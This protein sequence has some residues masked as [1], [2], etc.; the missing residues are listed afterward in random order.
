MMKLRPSSANPTRTSRYASRVN[1]SSSIKRDLKL[2][3]SSQET[4]KFLDSQIFKLTEASFLDY[5]SLASTQITQELKILKTHTNKTQLSKTT[6]NWRIEK[7]NLELEQTKSAENYSKKIPLLK[8]KIEKLKQEIIDAKIQQ[9]LKLDDR[10]VYFHIEKRMVDTKIHLELKAH[11]LRDQLKIK[12]A[13]LNTEK[14]KFL[15]VKEKRC[16]SA[17]AYK[18]F[19]KTSEFFQKSKKILA[20]RFEEEKKASENMD[21]MRQEHNR[22]HIEICEQ[23]DNEESIRNFK[24]I[25]ERVML[26]KLWY[27]FLSNKLKDYI[28]KFGTIDLA[29]RKIRSITGLTDIS[30]VVEKFLTKEN[31]YNELMSMVNQNKAI[32]D[33][34]IKDN[35][36]L[37]SKIEELNIC[38]K[39][40]NIEGNVRELL[41]VIQGNRVR[42]AYEKERLEKIQALK[43]KLE[44]WVKKVIGKFKIQADFQKFSIVEL[45]D[46]LRSTVLDELRGMNLTPDLKVMKEITKKVVAETSKLG[47]SPLASKLVQ[48]EKI[49]NEEMVLSHLNYSDETTDY[50]KKTFFTPLLEKAL[51][52]PL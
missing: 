25:R 7:L 52:K 21:L 12:D 26:S 17:R 45:I 6:N 27:M 1:P 29:F 48:K 22:R 15:N 51:R 8:E 11:H 10:E 31:L 32:K 50:K 23:V 36:D 39:H 18:N 14:M 19:D 44:A 37:Q 46:A 38:E 35:K 13:I 47:N 16:R 20:R 41:D 42:N 5:K 2:I 40:K 49:K 33:K 43:V 34:M 24:G 9:E 30:E 3:Q 28:T 4:G